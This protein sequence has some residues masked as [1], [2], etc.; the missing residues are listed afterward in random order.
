MKLFANNLEFDTMSTFF[1]RFC[2]VLCVIVFFPSG[3]VAAER[4][5]SDILVVTLRDSPSA[6]STPIGYL[7]SGDYMTVLE[8]LDSGDIRVRTSSGL[9]GWLQKSYTATG[10]SKNSLIQDLKKDLLN[11]EKNSKSQKMKN[12]ALAAQVLSLQTST[13]T[14]TTSEAIL[15]SRIVDLE[16]RVAEAEGKYITLKDQSQEVEAIYGERDT[17]LQDKE[18]LTQEVT[19]L[20]RDNQELK[21]MKNIFWFLAGSGVLLLGWLLGRSA[22]K[23]R[24]NSLTL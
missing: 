21:K 1:Q 19:V 3:L 15:Q 17:L 2:C 12:A 13:A 20:K 10:K 8:E 4:Y 14:A 9:E 16:K 24:R 5:V 11:L 22:R 23:N 6:T 7:R 18:A